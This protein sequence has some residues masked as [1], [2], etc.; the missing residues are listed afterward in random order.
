[1]KMKIWPFVNMKIKLQKSSHLGFFL[2]YYYISLTILRRRPL[3]TV[4]E[5][6]QIILKTNDNFFALTRSISSRETEKINCQG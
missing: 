4:L 3:G 5:M 1:M 6:L 2:D